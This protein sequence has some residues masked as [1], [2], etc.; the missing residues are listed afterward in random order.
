VEEIAFGLSAKPA[1]RVQTWISAFFDECCDVLQVSEAIARSGGVLRG[2]LQR[3][4]MVRTQADMLIAATAAHHGLTLVTHNICDF[5]NCGISL[6]D[7][8]TV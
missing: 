4:G 8:F 7:P 3:S 2:R 1:G 6:L 5:E